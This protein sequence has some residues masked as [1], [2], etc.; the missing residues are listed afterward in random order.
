MEPDCHKCYLYIT[1]FAWIRYVCA[2]GEACLLKAVIASLTSSH[3]GSGH[4]AHSNK[5]Y[6]VFSTSPHNAHGALACFSALVVLRCLFWLVHICL[7]MTDSMVII[8]LMRLAFLTVNSLWCLRNLLMK[9]FPGILSTDLAVLPQP[10]RQATMRCF[11]S[12]VPK[13]NP[14]SPE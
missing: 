4:R 2:V 13:G 11:R 9:S 1:L 14:T 7:F 3:R 10:S 8:S 12:M 6:M 5:R